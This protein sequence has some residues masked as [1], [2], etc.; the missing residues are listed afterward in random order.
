MGEVSG[1]YLL[2]DLGKHLGLPSE[3]LEI[4]L[5]ICWTVACW[6]WINAGR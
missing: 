4:N 1:H 6:T 3:G 2:A 5:G